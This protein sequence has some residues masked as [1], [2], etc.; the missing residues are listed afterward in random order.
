M[1]LASPSKVALA[2]VLVGGVVY[3]ARQL[4]APTPSA[5]PE[6][7]PPADDAEDAATPEASVASAPDASAPRC[8]DLTDVRF[9]LSA[10]PAQAG[11]LFASGAPRAAEGSLLCKAGV[12][13]AFARQED[14]RLMQKA[15][16]SFATELSKGLPQPFNGAHFVA[17]S[18]A[19]SPLFMKELSD[20]LKPLGPRFGAKIV[21]V[22]GTSRGV[23]RLIGPSAL[24]EQP[25]GARG[26]LIA[27][28]RGTGAHALAEAWVAAH[29][30]CSNPD[31]ASFDPACV[32]WLLAGTPAQAV[33]QFVEA[34]CEERPLVVRG[35]PGRAKKRV[36]VGAVAALPPGDLTVARARAGLVSLASTADPGLEAPL[37][38]IG[39]DAW[40]Q[41]NRALVEGMLGA[42]LA[43]GQAVRAGGEALQTAAE[44]GARV[45]NDG[46]SEV[47]TESLSPRAVPVDGGS[48]TLGGAE[49]SD[50]D[51]ALRAFG[52]PAG[53]ASP[54]S[55]SYQRYADALSTAHPE[56]REALPK[57]D[58]LLEPSYLKALSAP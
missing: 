33:S 37:V 50:R 36:C 52:L 53:G 24:T 35:K 7:A 21:A 28:A 6:P 3:A 25:E 39:I 20:A 12:D 54:L 58:D 5:S 9:L 11:A 43:G 48:V 40:M 19:A 44:I 1:K 13:V 18:A 51:D 31:P 10:H 17:I 23:E 49:V 47:W 32:N 22:L 16:V 45:Y 26:S 55:T 14:S 38:V 4:A 29:G 15:L 2:L 34:T 57:P 41:Q 56:L 30:L 27:A 8:V 42:L 46:V